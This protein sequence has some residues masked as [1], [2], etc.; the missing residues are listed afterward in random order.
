MRV[1]RRLLGWGAFLILVGAVPL[2][3]RAGLVD[4]QLVADWPSLWPLL[5]VAWGLGLLLRRTPIEWIGGALSAIVFGLMGGGALATGF[6]GVSMMSGCGGDAPGAA[7]PAQQGTFD[8]SGQLNVE[9]NCGTLSL[10]A[11]DSAAWR[12]SGTES[13]GRPPAIESS[14]TTVSIEGR[15]GSS[16]FGD[17]GAAQWMVEVPRAATLGLG[18]TLNAGSGHAVLDGASLSSVS[19]TLN[20][21]SFSLDLS[22]AESLG[23]VNA[24][25]NAGDGTLSLPGGGRSANLSLNAGN[26]TACLPAGSPIR[27][28]WSGA[29]G[30]NDLDKAGPVKIDN[31]TWTSVGFDESQAH[32]ELHVSANAGSFGLVMGACD[33]RATLDA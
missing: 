28:Q 17:A 15:D 10:D 13:Q 31:H 32:T 1:D 11:V 18:V 6:G 5:L 24:T 25:V 20:A 30:S 19:L 2:A 33:A 4:E 21:G 3:V 22:G 23:D 29:L 14:G 7:F 26:L 27:V 16:F 12:V 8:D 9:F